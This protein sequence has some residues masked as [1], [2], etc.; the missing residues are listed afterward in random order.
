MRGKFNI[1]YAYDD[2]SSVPFK[3]V[4]LKPSEK[5]ETERAHR[6]N[7]FQLFFLTHDGGKHL[8]DFEE[9]TCIANTVHIVNPGSVHKFSRTYQT[10]GFV[11]MF[12]RNF[13]SQSLEDTAL[14]LHRNDFSK[15]LTFPETVFKEVL[16][17]LGKIKHEQAESN[18]FQQQSIRSLLDLILITIQRHVKFETGRLFNESDELFDQFKTILNQNFI[19]EATLSFYADS[20]NISHQKLNKLCKSKVNKNARTLIQERILLEAKRLLFHAPL[21]IKEIA[22]DLGFEDPSYFN[23]LFKQKVGETPRSF[24]SSIREKY[25]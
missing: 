24:R 16:L 15:F 12:S 21:S 7:F 3:F 20:L 14:F 2:H 5:L 23:R 1:N 19:K 13:M 17:Y 4:V 10:H 25:H 22:F 8:V 6:H 9:Q 18:E 11:L